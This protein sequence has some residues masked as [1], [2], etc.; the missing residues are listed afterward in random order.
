M[1]SQTVEYALRAMIHLAGSAPTSLH[2][3][4]DR[5]NNSGAEGLSFESPAGPV[6]GGA[7]AVPTWSPRW[8]FAWKNAGNTD[9]TGDCE[10]G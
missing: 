6:A 5:S 7:G 8:Y 2:D 9:D 10:C 4:P 1:F 3:R